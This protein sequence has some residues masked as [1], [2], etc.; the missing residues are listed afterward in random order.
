MKTLYDIIKD[1]YE[2]KF[3]RLHT[4][5]SLELFISDRCCTESYSIELTINDSSNSLIT[6]CDCETGEYYLGVSITASIFPIYGRFMYQIDHV[7]WDFNHTKT[8]SDSVMAT[9]LKN[10]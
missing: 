4:S 1:V 8:Y 6:L 10:V 7:S 5:D 9:V 2:N 3:D